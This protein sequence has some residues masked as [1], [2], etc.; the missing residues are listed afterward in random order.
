M[1]ETGQSYPTVTSP[2]STTM[3]SSLN[4]SSPSSM[5]MTSPTS[6]SQGNGDRFTTP[7]FFGEM[8][9]ETGRHSYMLNAFENDVGIHKVEGGMP[10]QCEFVD[11]LMIKRNLAHKV[12]L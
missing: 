12:C 9:Q 11:G 3:N 2:S 5:T 8:S 10:E 7:T 6:P 1:M 4:P